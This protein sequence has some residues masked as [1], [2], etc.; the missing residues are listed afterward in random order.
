[1]VRHSEILIIKSDKSEIRRVESFL[2]DLFDKYYLPKN[3]FNRVYLCIS[4]AIVNSIQHGNENNCSKCIKIKLGYY[5]YRMD[6]EISD[7]GKGFDHNKISD[8]TDIENIKK[9]SGRGIHIIKSLCDQIEFK[10]SGSCI[11]IIMKVK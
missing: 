8:P 2:T 5:D 6:I 10:N 9:E 11:R 4:E 7:E 1:M 3:Q